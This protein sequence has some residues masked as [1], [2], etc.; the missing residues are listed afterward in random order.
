MN[1]FN[2]N[3]RQWKVKKEFTITEEDVNEYL[4]NEFCDEPRT[5]DDLDEDE[6]SDIL[7]D[8]AYDFASGLDFE[9]EELFED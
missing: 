7:E 3:S 4:K 6:L 5:I 9:F 8:I 1:L 2:L